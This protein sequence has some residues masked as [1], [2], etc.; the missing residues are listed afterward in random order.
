MAV[1][2]HDRPFRFFDL[3]R[4]IRNDIYTR[5]TSFYDDYPT[6]T[7]APKGR[8]RNSIGKP[9]DYRAGLYKRY[10]EFVSL[11]T[12]S[13]QFCDEALPIFWQGNEFS[14]SFVDINAASKPEL[15]E[16]LDQVTTMLGFI[17]PSGKM[18]ITRIRVRVLCTVFVKKPGGNQKNAEY[19][20]D[21]GVTIEALLEMMPKLQRLDISF[22]C[23]FERKNY[24]GWETTT[25]VLEGAA[26]SLLE[27]SYPIQ[28]LESIDM[29]KPMMSIGGS[30]AGRPVRA[31]KEQG[32]R[33]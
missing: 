7:L 33:V 23:E 11:F 31:A 17:P 8:L 19:D 16:P 10:R 6:I 9:S 32:T 18:Y 1:S 26:R 15:S 21:L 29:P 24:P 3:P 13:R 25:A 22:F 5:M 30:V 12:I 20:T 4:E 28:I 14:V 2:Y 27:F